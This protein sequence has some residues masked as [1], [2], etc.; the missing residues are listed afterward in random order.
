MAKHVRV[1]FYGSFINRQVLAA[2]GL[3]PDRVEVAR[4]WGFDI[5]A[6]PLVTLAPSDRDCVYGIVCEATHTELQRLYDQEWV[7]AYQ[8]EAVLV[9]AED[10]RVFPALCYI[11]PPGDPVPAAADYI[12]RIVGP[13]EEYR[14]PDW[15]VKRLKSLRGTA[16]D[17]KDV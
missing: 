13:A 7:A 9:Q 4:L 16:T 17:D 1:F 10:G 12:D 3:V 14:F 8:P 15:Y 11:A 6:Q 5:Q 2:V